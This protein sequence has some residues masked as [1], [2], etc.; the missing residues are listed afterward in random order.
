MSLP[1]NIEDG[2]GKRSL[3]GGRFPLALGGA[4]ADIEL[5]GVVGDE[6]VAWLGSEGG[7]VFIQTVGQTEPVICNGIPVATSQWLHDGDVVR[8]AATRIA[9]GI[10]DEGL[11]L[12]V[13]QLSD[14]NVTQPPQLVKS[15]TAPTPATTVRPIEFTPRQVEVKIRKRRTIR[16]SRIVVW[17]L[18]AALGGLAYLAFTTK[19]VQLVVEPEPDRLSVA[20]GPPS[21][22]MAD[23]HLMRP[24]TYTVVADR[25]GYRRLEVTIEVT[26]EPRQL[27]QFEM[28]KLP[29]L[30]AIDA[31]SVEG[32]EV[33][34]D[35]RVVGTTPLDA[36]ELEPGQYEVHVRADRY[37]PFTGPVSIEGEGKT[38]TLTVELVPQWAPVTFQS[39][40]PGARVKLD[41]TS[42]GRTPMTTDL[43]AGSYRYEVGLPGHKSH[44]GS[45]RVVANEPQSIQGVTLEV[46]D[47]RLV[48]VTEPEGA[49]VTVGSEY[50]GQTPAEIY[51]E[52]GRTHRVRLSKAGYDPASREIRLEAAET[53]ELSV[54]LIP[55]KGEVEV[56]TTPIGA[57]LYVNGAP[58]GK[59]N[60]TLRLVAVPHEIEVRKEGFETFRARVTPRPGFPQS[61]RVT[62]KTADEIKAESTPSMIRSPQGQAMILVRGGEFTMGAPRREPGRR[63]NE[64]QRKV[65]LTRPYYIAT[66]E[67]T[68]REFREYKAD[69]LSGKIGR[70]NLEVGH[71]PVVRVTWEEAALYCN[72]LSK[73]DNLPPAYLDTGG[74]VLA[75]DPLS[76]GY[77]LPTEAEWAWVA[78]FPDGSTPV[79]YPW[80]ASLPIAPGSGNYADESAEALLSNTISGYDDHFPATAPVDSFAPNA[81]GV[82]NLGGNVAEWVHDIYIVYR[83]D[84]GKVDEDPTGPAEGGYHVIRGGSW[85]DASVSELRLT[86]RDRGTE[87]RADLGFRIARYAE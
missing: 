46:S 62:L 37:D 24:G 11:H 59:G 34:I 4:D 8:I 21:L 60:Q 18:L 5:P 38:E 57:E 63:A 26:R 54:Q 39:R 29:G 6:P 16:P 19:A 85:M 86:Y 25:E 87:R 69:H 77:R 80:G 42:I 81:L 48:L 72:W 36:V 75:T 44:H 78:R 76:T 84:G 22:E 56:V 71:H 9:V 2:R 31:G 43:L 66:A 47:G 1:L 45:L 27:F 58:H 61:I 10:G 70:H 73:L 50:R 13:D 68:N 7:E 64:T 3:D 74:R 83:S 40:P 14:D 51:L 49:T 33:S 52:P 65:N 28:V 55:R 67:V 30:L 20:D 17:L 32:A 41:G 79:K 23:R 15:Q 35:G 12:K 53:R 82:F